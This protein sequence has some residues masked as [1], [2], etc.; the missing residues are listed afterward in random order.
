MKPIHWVIQNLNFDLIF[1][2]KDTQW[3]CDATFFLRAHRLKHSTTGIYC[4]VAFIWMVTLHDFFHGLKSW[5]HLVQHNSTIGKYCLVAGLYLHDHTLRFFNHRLKVRTSKINST[6]GKYCSIAL[7]WM[8]TDSKLLTVLRFDSGSKQADKLTCIYAL[9]SWTA[10]VVR[11]P[12]F[13]ALL[14][15]PCD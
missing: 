2:L 5:N 14:H 1:G 7:I 8:Q 12:S 4:S 9:T 3:C 6:T 11:W 10:F 15:F 13:L